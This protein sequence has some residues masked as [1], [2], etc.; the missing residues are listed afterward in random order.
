MLT[1]AAW[2]TLPIWFRRR[3]TS[4]QHEDNE[5]ILRRMQVFLP[6]KIDELWTMISV[7]KTKISASLVS[8]EVGCRLETTL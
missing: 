1:T 3:G 4:R 8:P 7:E 2:S 6:T 5:E